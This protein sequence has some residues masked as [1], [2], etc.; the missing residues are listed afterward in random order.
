[1]WKLI[2]KSCIRSNE[3]ELI[4]FEWGDKNTS[5]FHKFLS[6]R[7]K[8]NS[9]KGLKNSNR[10]WVEGDAALLDLAIDYFKDLFESKPVSN[11]DALTSTIL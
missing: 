9:V 10:R 8:R 5:F 7:K 1:M 2:R 6:H 4:G 3:P 11:S